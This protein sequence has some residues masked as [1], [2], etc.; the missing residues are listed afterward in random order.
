MTSWRLNEQRN[1]RRDRLYSDHTALV[2][3]GYLSQS[4]LRIKNNIIE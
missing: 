1:R 3:S 4:R 2:F